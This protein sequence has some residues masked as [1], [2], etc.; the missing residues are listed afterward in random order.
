[1]DLRERARVR[2]ASEVSERGLEERGAGERQVEVGAREE[3]AS[4][5]GREMDLR[6]GLQE[7][8]RDGLAGERLAR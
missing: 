4:D 3:V 1:M 5:G 7:R 8:A 6:E 2:V